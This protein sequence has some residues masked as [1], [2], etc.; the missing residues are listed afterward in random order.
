MVKDGYPFLIVLLVGSLVSAGLALAGEGWWFWPAGILFLQGLFV[1]WFFRN[2]E[3]EIPGGEETVV[4]PADGLVMVVRKVDLA[5]LPGYATW[6]RAGEPVAGEGTQITIF[7]SVFDVH[8][9]RTP[10]AGRIVRSEY[11]PGRFL[12]ASLERATQE[13]EQQIVTVSNDR[14]TVVFRMI[15]GLIARRIVLWK[16]EGEELARGE[17]VGLIRF[18]SRVD[19]I[20]PPQVEVLV[21]KGERVRGGS[22]V[23]GKVVG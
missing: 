22:S 1:A 15:A 8:V 10:I 6:V 14:M 3:R 16:Q 11:R 2:P 4:S 12:V 19:L 21:R 5:T 13:N 17:R 23:I 20:L 9:N 7:L 18:G